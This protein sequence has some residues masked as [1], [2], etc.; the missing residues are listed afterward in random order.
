MLRFWTNNSSRTY[1]RAQLNVD[2]ARTTADL[3]IVPDVA[4]AIPRLMGQSFAEQANVAIIRKGYAV[5]VL[6]EHSYLQDEDGTLEIIKSSALPPRI[7]RNSRHAT[8]PRWLRETLHGA[9]KPE[10]QKR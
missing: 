4:Q 10:R 8:K 2:A 7:L 5:R 6:E 9:R 1:T 3:L